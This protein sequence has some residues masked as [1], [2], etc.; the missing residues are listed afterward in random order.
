MMPYFML[1]I[2]KGL[3]YQNTINLSAFL[4]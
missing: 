1:I 2:I 4:I 3:N